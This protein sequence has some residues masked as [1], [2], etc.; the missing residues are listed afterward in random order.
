M[1]L[2]R[3]LA[4]RADLWRGHATPA[5]ASRGLATG[6]VALDE[7]LSGHGWPTGGLS[8]VL[9]AHLG[10]GLALLL[11]LLASLSRQPRWLLWVDPPH[12]P[13]APA[14]AARGLDLRRIL[15]VRAGADAAWAAEQ[16]LRSRTCAA[17]LAWTDST[18]HGAIARSAPN[19]SCNQRRLATCWTPTALRRL[20]IAAA[21]HQVPTLLL[22]SPAAAGETSPA[23]LR[24]RV[25]ACPD[26]LDV[27]V[28]K[29]RGGRPG[30]RLRLPAR[31]DAAPAAS[32]SP[33]A[34]DGARRP[35]TADE[36]GPSRSTAARTGSSAITSP[37]PRAP[38]HGPDGAASAAPE[39][40]ETPA[41]VPR[42][43]ESVIARQAMIAGREACTAPASRR[44]RRRRAAPRR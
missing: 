17:V 42:P 14:L 3:L 16:G 15:L 43:S 19:G 22:R 23:A 40:A 39:P 11:P 7:A 35:T 8:E 30:Q 18:G 12:L 5:A 31:P 26:G 37:A 44:G 21:D 36:I 20:Q 6:F 29:Q 28:L 24:L 38:E 4:A 2:D 27:T 41:E 33:A 34:A 9:T 25:N 32:T 13:F 10:A 1:Q